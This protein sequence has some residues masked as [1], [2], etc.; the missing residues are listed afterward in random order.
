MSSYEDDHGYNSATATEVEL[1]E[2]IG[3]I[4]DIEGD[5]DYFGFPAEEGETYYLDIELD[6]LRAGWL[7][8]DDFAEVEPK[9]IEITWTNKGRL[10]WTADRTG[11][12]FFAVIPDGGSWTGSYSVQVS[13]S[14]YEDDHADDVAEASIATLVRPIRGYLGAI[15]DVDYFKFEA[16]KDEYYLINLDYECPIYFPG[17]S[18]RL[19]REYECDPTDMRIT[20]YASDGTELKY[21][22]SWG[23]DSYITMKWIAIDDGEFYVSVSRDPEERALFA[24]LYAIGAEV[25]LERDHDADERSLSAEIAIGETIEA[26]IGVDRDVDFFKFMA[27]TGKTYFVYLDL[28]G[29]DYINASVVDVNDRG[30]LWDAGCGPEEDKVLRIDAEESGYHYVALWG[31]D[32]FG[33]CWAAMGS[34]SIRV[35]ESD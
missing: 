17:D 1:G 15:D 33:N 22:D 11:K 20:L 4:I 34:Y 19:I 6:T 14:D 25:S 9:G 2:V 21:Q 27:E 3:G 26:E 23:W 28:F 18:Y 30:L 32:A 24:N 5:V 16:V 29:L 13:L 35:E 10:I 12:R 8:I 31:H 7:V